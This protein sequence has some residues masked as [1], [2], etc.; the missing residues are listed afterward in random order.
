MYQILPYSYEKA[1]QLGVQIRPSTNAKKKI[2]VYQQGK[3]IAS[4]GAK[5]YSDY[6]HYLMNQPAIAEERRKAYHKRHKKDSEKIGT[7]GYYASRILW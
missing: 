6:P 7:P 2:D 1:K 5:G 4:I 3:K